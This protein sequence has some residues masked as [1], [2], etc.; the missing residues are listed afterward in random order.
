MRWPSRS[1]VF[2][3]HFF[4]YPGGI[5]PFPR[6]LRLGVQG[7]LRDSTPAVCSFSPMHTQA[8]STSREAMQGARRGWLSTHLDAA[9]VG[10]SCLPGQSV[11]VGAYGVAELITT[12]KGDGHG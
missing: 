1:T 3:R 4:A 9:I 7:S 10:T 2:S 12:W 6:C 11:E 5:P 8:Q